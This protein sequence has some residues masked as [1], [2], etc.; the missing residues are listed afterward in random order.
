MVKGRRGDAVYR[1]CGN[2]SEVKDVP[3]RHQIAGNAAVV[4]KGRRGDAVHRACG[5]GSEVKDV[6]QRHLITGNA[7]VAVKGRRTMPRTMP[8]I[9]DI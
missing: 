6:P 1:A 7:A 4:V 5:N 8:I 2:G 3:Q 9:W